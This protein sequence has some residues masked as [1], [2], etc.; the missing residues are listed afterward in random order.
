MACVRW[1]GHD[2]RRLYPSGVLDYREL[3]FFSLSGPSVRWRRGGVRTPLLLDGTCGGLEAAR[4]RV[5][6]PRRAMRQHGEVERVVRVQLG[7]LIPHVLL[8]QRRQ[9]LVVLIGDEANAHLS[10]ET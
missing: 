3:Y 1:V 9:A 7:E 5:A 10:A 6:H 2:I 4:A 8:E